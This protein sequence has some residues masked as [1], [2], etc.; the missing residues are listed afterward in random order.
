MRYKSAREI[1]E[2][3]VREKREQHLNLRIT[4]KSASAEEEFKGKLKKIIQ[5]MLE[6]KQKEN[7]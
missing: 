1:C 2:K 6:A 5:I 4:M 7:T 3:N